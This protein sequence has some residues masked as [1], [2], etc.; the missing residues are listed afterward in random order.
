VHGACSEVGHTPLWLINFGMVDCVEDDGFVDVGHWAS[1]KRR[2]LAK[3]RSQVVRELLL[4]LEYLQIPL[5]SLSEDERSCV[6][7]LD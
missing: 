4:L 2:D 1:A 7:E 5:S 6:V 3:E